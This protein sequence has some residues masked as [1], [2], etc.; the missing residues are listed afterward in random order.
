MPDLLA[1]AFSCAGAGQGLEPR[2]LSA[3]TASV[4][5]ANGP[6]AEL[7]FFFNEVPFFGW[8]KIC[9]HNSIYLWKNERDQEQGSQIRRISTKFVEMRLNR[10]DLNSKIGE[11]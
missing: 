5:Q 11:F 9:F 8:R 6:S 3:T 2:R 10:S 4:Q 1:A 7:A